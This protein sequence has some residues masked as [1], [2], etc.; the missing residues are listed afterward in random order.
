MAV[1]SESEE[2]DEFAK[3]N[4]KRL[5][6]EATITSRALYCNYVTFETTQLVRNRPKTSRAY[7]RLSSDFGVSFFCCPCCLRST[8]LQEK[9]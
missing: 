8:D 5:T 7:I 1:C 4:L 3:S 9:P 6:G 2:T